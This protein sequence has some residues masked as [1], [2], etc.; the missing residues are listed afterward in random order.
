MVMVRKYKN[1]TIKNIFITIWDEFVYGSHLLAVGDALVVTSLSVI[2]GFQISWTL[3]VVIYLSVLAINSY[4]RYKEFDQDILTNPE[5]SEKM[6]KHIRFFPYLISLELVFAASIVLISANRQALIFMGLLFVLGILYTLIFKG[7]TKKIIGFKNFSIALPYSLMVVFMAY[8]YNYL[9]STTVILIA[10]FYYMRIFIS[11]MY[12]DIKD[13]E[14]DKKEGLK[15]FAVVF[16]KEKTIN[17]LMILN[18]LSF[19]PIIIGI[20]YQLLPL[21]SVGLV[22]TIPYAI[23]YIQKVNDKKIKKSMLYNLVADGEFVF[24]LP[25]ILIAKIIFI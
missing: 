10:I 4:N 25:Y 2:L 5:R 22:L 3:P 8:Y 24:W 19:V 1:L 20:Y 13:I 14:G 17:I 18:I 23:Y 15:T 21:F 11:A 12:F 6:R 7:W 16:G 9:I